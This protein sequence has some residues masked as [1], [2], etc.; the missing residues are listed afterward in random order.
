MKGKTEL[1][2]VLNFWLLCMHHF[3]WWFSLIP[4]SN[5][6]LI[7]L[8]PQFYGL[9]HF[10]LRIWIKCLKHIDLNV[11]TLLFLNEEYNLNLSIYT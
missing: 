6:L 2:F 4:A 11:L 3:H 5:A 10:N 9:N 8:I 1:T 7:F